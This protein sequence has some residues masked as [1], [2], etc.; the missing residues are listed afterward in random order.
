MWL[1]LGGARRETAPVRIPGAVRSWRRWSRK[2]ARERRTARAVRN[3][4]S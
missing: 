3:W 1:E 4:R 2:M